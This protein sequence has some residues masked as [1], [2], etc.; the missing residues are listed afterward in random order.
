MRSLTAQYQQDDFIST[1]DIVSAET[2]LKHRQTLESEQSK[3]GALHYNPKAHTI[4]KSP[5]EL[6][7]DT[8]WMRS[9][10]LYHYY[11]NDIPAVSV[12]DSVAIGNQAILQQRFKTIATAK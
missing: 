8:E 3:V 11:H 7:I 9:E 4:L 1:V 12:L 10:N 6:T 2:V 5:V